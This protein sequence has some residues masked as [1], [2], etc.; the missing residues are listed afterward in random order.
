VGR[1]EIHVNFQ[2]ETVK[3]RDNLGDLGVDGRI[4]F[5]KSKVDLN[6]CTVKGVG[7]FIWRR[8]VTSGEF[9][10]TR[11]WSF[12]FHKKQAVTWLAEW[13]LSSQE[14]LC[15]MKLVATKKT[16]SEE[17]VKLHVFLT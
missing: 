3:G 14:R 4:S 13:L 17:E 7:E 11:K 10:W 16:Y 6:S 2:L 9:L 1:W 12:G 8:T 5:D 15:T